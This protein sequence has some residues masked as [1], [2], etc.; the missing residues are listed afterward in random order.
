MSLAP[1]IS[2]PVILCVA[3]LSFAAGRMAVRPPE[4]ESSQAPAAPLVQREPERRMP[5]ALPDHVPDLAKLPFVET[6]RIIKSASPDMVAAYYHELEQQPLS[7][8]RAAAMTMFFKTLIQ[9]NPA[10]TKDF[11]LQLKKDDRWLPM[12]AIR[13]AA[14]PAGMETVAEVLLSFDPG[15]ISGCSFDYLRDSLD[16]WGQSDPLALKQFLESHPDKGLD[17][18]LGVLMVN[19]A[20]TDPEAAREWMTNEI[21]KRPFIPTEMTADG[22]ERIFDG[23]WRAAVQNMTDGWVRGFF[24]NDPDRATTYVLEHADNPAVQQALS[25]VAGDLF[26]ISP[27]RARDFILRLPKE[28]QSTSLEGISY[29]ANELVRSDAR[30]NTTSPRYVAEWMRQFPAEVYGESMRSVV[31]VWLRSNPSELFSW[32]ADLP[33]P[34]RDEMLRQ[35]P[36]VSSSNAQQDFDVVIQLPDP[37]LRTQLLEHYARTAG[38]A[39]KEFRSVLEN[40]QLPAQERARLI[41]LIPQREDE[42]VSGNE[43]AE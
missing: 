18:Q 12:W 21:E 35:F 25:W 27:E 24:T 33:A 38:Y 11:I 36:T 39:D 14:T 40:S 23:E 26:L 2:V 30:D 43:E 9:A 15:E 32:M 19:W 42:T 41:N 16:E 7:P 1:K 10:L 22:G 20:A 37:V 4:V 13:E 28:Q 3:A 31:R 6:Y 34:T 29:A 17:R 8:R 5:G